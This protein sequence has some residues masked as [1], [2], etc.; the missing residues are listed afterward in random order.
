MFWQPFTYSA[1][2]RPR[3]GI[4]VTLNR[5]LNLGR[6]KWHVKWQSAKHAITSDAA[7]H[8]GQPLPPLRNIAI[9]GGTI[10]MAVAQ[11][12]VFPSIGDLTSTTSDDCTEEKEGIGFFSKIIR[13]LLELCYE[14]AKELCVS[15]KSFHPYC[16]TCASIDGARGDQSAR[17]LFN[18]RNISCAIFTII[19]LIGF[20]IGHSRFIHFTNISAKSLFCHSLYVYYS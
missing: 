5:E 15:I 4:K 11:S 20:N 9:G 10:K 6:S 18:D 14:P 19:S 17:T 1:R 2:L 3:P 13:C 8:M 16:R 7:T 12:A